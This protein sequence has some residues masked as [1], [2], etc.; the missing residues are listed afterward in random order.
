MHQINSY[1]IEEVKCF[2][3]LNKLTGEEAT[4]KSQ[5]LN[6]SHTPFGCEALR[7]HLWQWDLQYH[8]YTYICSLIFLK[9]SN[10]CSA[11]ESP[12]AMRLQLSA[13]P[14]MNLNTQNEGETEMMLRLSDCSKVSWIKRETRP[15]TY[16]ML[17]I[18][19]MNSKA[20]LVGAW[21]WT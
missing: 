21:H 19:D 1:E 20:E 11:T 16:W 4:P 17:S 10:S 6:W 13:P 2:F 8:I 9:S 18:H 7:P 5:K 12:S 15:R 3:Y 14:P